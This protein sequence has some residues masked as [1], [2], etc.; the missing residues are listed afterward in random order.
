MCRNSVVSIVVCVTLLLLV[1]PTTRAQEWPVQPTQP[2]INE[3]QSGPNTET[4]PK[5]LEF[6]CQIWQLE[7]DVQER[8]LRARLTNTTLEFFDTHYRFN[9]NASSLAQTLS[10]GE[11]LWTIMRGVYLKGVI[12]GHY[13]A[14]TVLRLVLVVGITPNPEMLEW[15]RARDEYTEYSREEVGD[16]LLKLDVIGDVA[17]FEWEE[18]STGGPDQTYV[19]SVR[20]APFSTETLKIAT[21]ETGELTGSVGVLINTL[22]EYT[23]EWLKYYMSRGGKP[24]YLLH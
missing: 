17:A 15:M 10:T 6:M 1:V 2:T 23:A 19:L 13:L 14:P 11:E 21:S 18:Q 24:E 20:L 3:L 12:P 7:P 16:E 8:L 22:R 4:I 9:E 5:M